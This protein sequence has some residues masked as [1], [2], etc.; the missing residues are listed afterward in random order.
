MKE[1]MSHQNALSDPEAFAKHSAPP[2]NAMVQ[3]GHDPPALGLF[4]YTSF[5][6]QIMERPCFDAGFDLHGFPLVV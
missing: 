6:G 1:P 4:Y 2:A 3:K 5:Q